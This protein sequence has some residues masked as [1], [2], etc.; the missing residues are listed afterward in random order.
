[1]HH[2]TYLFLQE[3]V[4]L[5]KENFE[6]TFLLKCTGEALPD[7]NRRNLLALI[8]S[9]QMLKEHQNQFITSLVYNKW[10]R[11]IKNLFPQERLT[12]Y[13]IPPCVT[14]Q[15]QIH[16][17]RGKL[18]SQVLNNRR[19][20]HKLGILGKKARSSNSD[21]R[22][23]PSVSNSESMNSDVQESL[24]WLQNSSEPWGLVIDKWDETIEERQKFIKE[25]TGSIEEYLKKYPYI[26]RPDGYKLV[27][28]AYIFLNV[29]ILIVI[30]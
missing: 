9:K 2:A 5:L 6:T 4:N 21:Q 20:F 13:Y 3:L 15:G 29:R 8:I 16:Q 14:A 22:Q 28:F 7:E 30:C 25:P 27:S 1:M 18:V 24:I 23:S 26:Q 10:C 17:A 11:E 19:K 12:T